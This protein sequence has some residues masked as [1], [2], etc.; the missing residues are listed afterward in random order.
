MALNIKALAAVDT[1]TLHVRGADDELL[2]DGDGDDRQPVEIVI[3]GPGTKQYRKAKSDQENRIVAR[4]QKR[5]AAA[6]TPEAR[7]REQAE[8]LADVTA[9]IRQMSYP[10]DDG[11][12]LTGRDLA[13]A[14]YRDPGIGFIAD[15]VHQVAHNWANFSKALPTA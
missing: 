7:A 1:H 9:E 8:F 2:Y 5:G 14:I 4:L 12:P 15:Q 13:V 3:Y 11:Q 10:G 6:Q